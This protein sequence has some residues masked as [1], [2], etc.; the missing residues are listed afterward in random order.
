M[1]V[2]LGFDMVFLEEG[3]VT[4]FLLPLYKL[5]ILASYSEGWSAKKN[6]PSGSDDQTERVIGC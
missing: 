4:C 6:V 5:C 3:A 1:D 2:T